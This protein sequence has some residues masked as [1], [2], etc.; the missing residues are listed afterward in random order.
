MCIVHS[1]LAFVP[2]AE[3]CFSSMTNCGTLPQ[4]FTRQICSLI[5]RYVHRYSQHNAVVEVNP[6]RY[7]PRLSH[8]KNRYEEFPLLE[9]SPCPHRRSFSRVL[10]ADK[11]RK[12]RF[13]TMSGQLVISLDIPFAL[14]ST[15]RR[16]LLGKTR[17]TSLDYVSRHTLSLT[18]AFEIGGFSNLAVAHSTLWY[19]ARAKDVFSVENDFEWFQR[20]K[21]MAGGFDNLH[22]T[23]T[24]SNEDF[25]TQ[26]AKAGGKFDAIVIDSQPRSGGAFVSSDDFR[27]ACLRASVDYAAEN[28]MLL[29]TILM[30]CHC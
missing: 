27:V 3:T 19:A 4:Q 11:Y 6:N 18:I 1:D 8:Y 20:V 25:V 29:V 15:V 9:T 17:R 30:P 26:I 2:I 28:C 7:I 5:F 21:S 12:S 23:F 13:H 24:E 14:A 22:L 16:S 10:R